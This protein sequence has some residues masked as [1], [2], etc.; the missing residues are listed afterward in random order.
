MHLGEVPH[1]VLG[2]LAL[3][4]C[5]LELVNAVVA[6]HTLE[7]CGLELVAMRV[8][9]GHGDPTRVQRR[10]V[11]TNAAPD[12]DDVVV[13]LCACIAPQRSVWSPR[14]RPAPQAMQQC[15]RLTAKRSGRRGTGH[16]PILVA[17]AALVLVVR[18]A[19]AR[20]RPATL[21][22]FEERRLRRAAVEAREIGAAPGT[23]K[24]WAAAANSRAA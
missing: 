14:P 15:L 9:R 22:W 18:S 12:D 10:A 11:S 21:T 23:V 13:E 3:L 5:I 7:E 17:V 24:A 4:P 19:G 1:E 20:L 6:R 8:H 2:D 16:I